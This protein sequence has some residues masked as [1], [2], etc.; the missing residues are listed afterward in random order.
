MIDKLYLILTIIIYSISFHANSAG[1]MS[2]DQGSAK[3][4]SLKSQIS[5]A[6]VSDESIVNYEVIN[7]NRI[8]IYG[9]NPGS[10]SII[11]FGHGGRE[12][13]NSDVIV[14]KNLRQLKQLLVANFPNENVSVSNLGDQVVLNGVVSSE[15]VK[16]KIYRLVGE[17]LTKDRTKK[18]SYVRD[19][20]GDKY[21][22]AYTTEYG[23]E[24]IVNNLKVLATEQI[25]VKLTIAEV[26]TS[27]LSNIGIA[28]NDGFDTGTF[29]N[30]ILDFT[31]EDIVTIISAHADD[32]I[33]TV[34]AEP[35]L[36]VISGERASFHVGGEMPIAVRDEDGTTIE[37]KEYGIRLGLIAKVSDS[38]NIRL[39][40]LPEVSSIDENHTTSTG[41]F[42]VPLFKT[43]KAETTVQLKNGQSFVL[44]G[45]LTTEE[46]ESLSKVPFLGD[47][48]ILGALFRN[49]K[50]STSKTELV[51]VATVNLVNPVENNSVKLPKLNRT[52]D[53]K[54]LLNLDLSTISEPELK[55]T[56]SE[57]GFN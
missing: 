27:F 16:L 43:R 39:T 12:I 52:S 32:N 33:G 19:I 8:V 10:A 40:M 31:A 48:P 38:N 37:Y 47:L 46:K 17:M 55:T 7:K 6:F 22:L 28:Y 1:L 51:I 41:Y 25:N 5:T 26:S 20:N 36:S 45:L 21:D 29:V 53:I 44:A 2:L 50:T 14:N 3:T 42:D 57:G 15:E 49:S 34:L 9:V 30:K 18:V 11:I 4:I 23:Y 13:Y 56:I 54:R 35:N 24:Q